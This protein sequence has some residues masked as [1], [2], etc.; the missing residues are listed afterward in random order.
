MGTRNRN[1]RS[2]PSDCGKRLNPA[3]KDTLAVENG[4]AARQPKGEC[5]RLGI[6]TSLQAKSA[7]TVCT[8]M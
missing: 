2:L 3:G 1:K 6:S 7:E 4:M 8:G 5:M